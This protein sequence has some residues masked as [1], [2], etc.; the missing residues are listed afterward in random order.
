MSTSELDK[1]K[2]SL[3]EIARRLNPDDFKFV[4]ELEQE[5]EK[6]KSKLQTTQDELNINIARIERVKLIKFP[7]MLR[8]IWSSTKIQE[9]LSSHLDMALR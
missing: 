8:M 3:S 5:I 7:T 6:I 4:V 2:E 9:W 1:Y